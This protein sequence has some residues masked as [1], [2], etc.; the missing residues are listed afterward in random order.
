MLMPSHISAAFPYSETRPLVPK[1]LG[2]L[3]IPSFAESQ[4]LPEQPKSLK[5]RRRYLSSKNMCNFTSNIKLLYL[6]RF[7]FCPT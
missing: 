3:L 7:P 2:H 6:G 5:A 1:Q 4:L